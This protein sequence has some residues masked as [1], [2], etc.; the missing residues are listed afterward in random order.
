MFQENSEESSDKKP[1]LEFIFSQLNKLFISLFCFKRTIY[2]FFS[3][4]IS[5]LRN[6]PNLLKPK[7][8][9]SLSSKCANQLLESKNKALLSLKGHF[10]RL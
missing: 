1:P 7:N 2:G 8:K 10:K 3:N 5:V 6:F 4:K 9:T